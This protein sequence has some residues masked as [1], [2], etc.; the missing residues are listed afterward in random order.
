MKPT[1]HSKTAIWN[2][3][4]KKRFPEGCLSF[5]VCQY[6]WKVHCFVGK[7]DARVPG[8]LLVFFLSNIYLI[9]IV[10]LQNQI[11][12]NPLT[13]IELMQISKI[14]CNSANASSTHTGPYFHFVLPYSSLCLSFLSSWWKLVVAT[15]LFANLILY[16]EKNILVS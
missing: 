16:L 10:L 11:N 4:F 12:E 15:W 3:N 1:F 13:I 7:A 2:Y 14:G 5:P 8:I 9:K 6:V